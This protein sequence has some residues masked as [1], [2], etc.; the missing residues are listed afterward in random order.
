MQKQITPNPK[1]WNGRKKVSINH[2]KTKDK[3]LTECA[4]KKGA[5]VSQ[6]E[7]GKPGN[8]R[9]YYPLVEVMEADKEVMDDVHLQH[10]R[11]DFGL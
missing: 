6:C 8:G 1:R 5:K 2:T 11:S 4:Y 9:K 7:T 3:N 10:L